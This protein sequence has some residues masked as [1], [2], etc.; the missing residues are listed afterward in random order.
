M[1]TRVEPLAGF[2]VGVTSDRRSG[3]LIAA[4]E[5][6][7]AEVL[8]APA[9]RIAPHDQ[10]GP[11]I[12]QTRA[13]IEER[14]EVVLVTT[15]YGVRRWFEV[16]DAGGLGA[17]LTD[18]LEHAVV[19]ARGPKAVGAVRAAGLDDHRGAREYDTT[20]AMVDD[21][22]ASGLTRKRVAIQV[23]GY[24]DEMQVGRLREVSEQVLTVTPY[25]WVSP[26]S[27]D[28]LNRLIQAACEQR[29]D[30]VAFTSAPGVE[31]TL[32]AAERSG[33][34]DQLI[35]A[36]AG[37][38][39]PFA[40]GPMTAAPLRANGLDP[41]VPERHRL[42]A[43]IRLICDRLDADRARR[44]RFGDTRIE[45]RG[46]VVLVDDRPLSLAP[47]ALDLL[48]M[49]VD[50]DRVVSRAELMGCLSDEPDDHALDVAMSRLRQSLGVPGLITTVVKRGYRFAGELDG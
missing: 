14:P 28:R 41:A 29:L 7:G 19:M 33:R 48:R 27:P 46:H 50:N 23:H 31:A 32:A 21:L 16:A 13:V 36:L 22:I 9:L 47:H 18:A 20:A 15:G 2:R 4:L 10:D 12:A 3:D 24:T 43:M 44:F 38:V 5:R 49:L 11:V 45:L 6:R 39:L 42:G 30:A 8:H 26:R 40:V 17:E 37:G 35:A 1:S 34:R 25:R